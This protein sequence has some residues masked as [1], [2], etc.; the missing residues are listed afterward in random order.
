ML[1]QTAG[2]SEKTMR[3]RLAV[4]TLAWL[5][6]LVTT[7]LTVLGFCSQEFGSLTTQ[8]KYIDNKTVI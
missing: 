5:T 8:Q 2:L 1:G 7:I 6:W 3:E 4:L